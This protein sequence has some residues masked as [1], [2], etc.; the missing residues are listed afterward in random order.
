MLQVRRK[1]IQSKR[2]LVV[3]DVVISKE[4]EEARNNRPLGRVVQVYPSE[5]G[6]VRKVKLLMADGDLDDCG[7]RQSPPSY[8]D[9]PI[10]KL[11]LLLT[12]DEVAGEDTLNQ[13]TGDVPTEKPTRDI[14]GV[15]RSD[16]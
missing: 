9:R 11:V 6:L 1:W 13:E 3:G 16:V 15:M 8:L 2:N 7:K 4:S 14:G 12:T 5:D 10:H